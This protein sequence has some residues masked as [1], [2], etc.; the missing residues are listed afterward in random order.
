[1]SLKAL[2]VSIIFTFIENDGYV[3]VYDLLSQYLFCVQK[4]SDKGQ[5]SEGLPPQPDSTPSTIT[6]L[7]SRQLSTSDSATG[8]QNQTKIGKLFVTIVHLV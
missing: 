7:T 4:S 3:R 1:M 5:E 2:Y 6:N 8:Q